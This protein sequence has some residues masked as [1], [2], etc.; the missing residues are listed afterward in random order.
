MEKAPKLQFIAERADAELR[1]LDHLFL[2]RVHLDSIAKAVFDTSTNKVSGPWLVLA[3][4]QA[5]LNIRFVVEELMLLSVSALQ[6][7]GETVSSSIR[8]EYRA[9]KI[10]KKLAEINPN[11]FPIAISLIKSE[12]PTVSGQFV[13]REG[14]H[15]TV[16]H[17]VDYWNKS[18]DLLHANHRTLS[19]AKIVASIRQAQ[20]FLHLTIGLLSMFEVDVSGKGMWIGGYLNFG[21]DR[22]PE[23]FYAPTVR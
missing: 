15:L 18:G 17:A 5:Q 16:A 12:D 1:A 20:E 7:A 2:I 4:R 9:G 19:E 11:F 8:T 6:Q 13:R 21:E 23:L 10:A 22:A 3:V 14:Q